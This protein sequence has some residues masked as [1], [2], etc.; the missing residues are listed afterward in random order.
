MAKR[1]QTTGQLVVTM[2]KSRPVVCAKR[3]TK[4]PQGTPVSPQGVERTAHDH[5]SAGKGAASADTFL[6][7]DPSLVKADIC[8][9]VPR[10]T[11][12]IQDSTKPSED[13]PVIVEVN[14]TVGDSSEFIDDPDVPPLE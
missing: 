5:R 13:K 10:E 3:Q 9:I 11:T 12:P 4:P 8:N 6:E 14:E 1:S 2:P 7:V